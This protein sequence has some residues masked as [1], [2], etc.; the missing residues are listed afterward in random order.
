MENRRP[1]E[2]PEKKSRERSPADLTPSLVIEL[3]EGKASAAK[4]L[5]RLYRSRLTRFCLG[6]L[7]R[8][9]EAEDVVQEVFYKVIQDGVVPDRFRPWIYEIC[10]NQCVDRLRKQNRRLDDQPLPRS[11]FINGQLTGNLTRLVKGEKRA[12]LL[13]RLGS[14]PNEQREVLLLR[15]T[16]GL[17]RAEIAE[18]LDIPEKL[19]KH[20]IYNGLERLRKHTSLADGN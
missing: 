12:M 2:L 6:Y 18:V 15:Y 11:S 16:E 8:W 3:R 13:K 5:D 9:E 17:S 14:L 1:P 4:L 10:R 7:G 20:R 19:V